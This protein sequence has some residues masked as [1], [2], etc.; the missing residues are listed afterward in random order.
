MLGDA[1]LP[2]PRLCCGKI[3]MVRPR[4]SA[5]AVIPSQLCLLRVPVRAL[6][7][8]MG[9]GTG[10]VYFRSFLR[11][12]SAAADSSKKSSDSSSRFW[13]ASGEAANRFQ[14]HGLKK[15]VQ[16]DPKSAES[17]S[18]STS[19][20]SSSRARSHDTAA[21]GAVIQPSLHIASSLCR[22]RGLCRA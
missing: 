3:G 16:S 9:S 15:C 12:T 11:F 21:D 22:A 13:L 19:S 2:F 7:A 10:E 8:F 4:D 17:A 20:R 1:R 14:S 6:S 18:S 5:E